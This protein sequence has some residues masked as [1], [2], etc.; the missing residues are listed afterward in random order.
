MHIHPHIPESGSTAGPSFPASPTGGAYLF[1][2][3][4]TPRE[5]PGHSHSTVSEG[6]VFA[7][8]RSPNPCVGVDSLLKCLED[9]VRI[10]FNPN[11]RCRPA[12]SSILSACTYPEV[13]QRYLDAEVACGNVAGPFSS[14]QLPAGIMYNRFGCD[15]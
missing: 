2:H 7:A 15:D 12:T 3:S 5:S 1:R 9:G 14:E 10:G 8:G 13:V 11:S 6:L 4:H